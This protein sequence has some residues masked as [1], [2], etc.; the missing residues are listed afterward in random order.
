MLDSDNVSRMGHLYIRYRGIIKNRNKCLTPLGKEN[1][2][3][4]IKSFLV[5]AIICYIGKEMLG[6]K[7]TYQRPLIMKN[8]LGKDRV[9]F[10]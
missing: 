8:S 5:E 2:R 6:A 9:D 3:A 7:D 10:E 4:A 1:G